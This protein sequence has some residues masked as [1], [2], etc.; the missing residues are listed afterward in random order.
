MPSAMSMASVL[1]VPLINAVLLLETFG[2]PNSE[3]SVESRT[4]N[5]AA[6]GTMP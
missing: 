6:T 1:V 2:T 3:A 5:V 4:N